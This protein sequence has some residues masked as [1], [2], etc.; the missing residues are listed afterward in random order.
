M[1]IL[2]LNSLEHRELE[3][4]K[5]GE[6]LS[7]SSVLSELIDFTQFFTSHE[8]IPP[9]RKAS[10]PHSHSHDEEMFLI[11]EGHPTLHHG[12][13]SYDL[14]PGDFV[15]LQPKDPFPHHLEN[16]TNHEARVLV[17]R[18][19]SGAD[20]VV[21][22]HNSENPIPRLE[23]SR[24]VLRPFALSDAKDVQR[25]AGSSK[26]AEMTALIPHPYLDG[27]AE[28]WISTHAERF[29]K[30]L[31]V[32]WAMTLKDTG[33]LVGCISLGISQKHQR[34]EI[35]YWVGEE[36]WNRGYCSEAASTVIDFAF[37]RLQLRKITSRHMAHNP[38]SGKV[39]QKA[40]MTQEGYL[41]MDFN[42]DGR[43][44]DMVVY[45]ITNEN[46]PQT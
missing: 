43:W 28:S 30:G 23:T 2:N 16:K 46:V 5:T 21:Y 6:K 7:H 44:V 45:G 32:D 22:K 1:K 12:E 15:G 4:K 34:A 14:S 40:G 27:M 25:M 33:A 13:K 24:L 10:S 41:K 31:A 11:L 18:A 20:E 42:K 3:I 19:N 26:V 38:A 36:F 39:M 8:I 35:G 29:C 9:G 17:I 37:K